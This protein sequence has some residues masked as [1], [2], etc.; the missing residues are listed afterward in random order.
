M[1]A[2][3]ILSSDVEVFWELKKDL[4]LRNELHYCLLVLWDYHFE[5]QLTQYTTTPSVS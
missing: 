3:F 1:Y 5:M 2:S 4:E